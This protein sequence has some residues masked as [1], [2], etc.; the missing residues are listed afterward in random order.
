MSYDCIMAPRDPRLQAAALRIAAERLE[1]GGDLGPE[2]AEAL[3]KDL[4][5]HPDEVEELAAVQ[6]QE[7]PLPQWMADA[8]D[9]R[10]RDDAGTEEDGDVVMDRLLGK[11]GQRRESA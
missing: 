7:G 6:A 3:A 4:A 5:R 2:L 10:E 1:R 8:L 9:Q 11:H